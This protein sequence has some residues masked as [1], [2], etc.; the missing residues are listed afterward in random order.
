MQRQIQE[1]EIPGGMKKQR[2]LESVERQSMSP[3]AS[4]LAMSDS[5]KKEYARPA[6]P[7][8]STSSY[9]EPKKYEYAHPDEKITYTTYDS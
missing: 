3:E 6:S 2:N 9:A 4:A 1:I 5:P 8:Y 7:K